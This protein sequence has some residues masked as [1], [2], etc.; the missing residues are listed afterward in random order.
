MVTVN[1]EKNFISAVIYIRNN[2]EN[3]GEFL[4]FINTTLELNFEQYEI[5]CVND[6][7]N[8]HSI[9]KIRDFAKKVKNAEISIL[10]MSFYHGKEISM[11]AGVD[12]SIGDFVY[13]FDTID[14]DY[15]QDLIMEIYYKSL[16]GYDLVK[17][18]PDIKSRLSSKIFYKVFNSYASLPKE[19]KTEMFSILSR[20]AINRIKNVNNEILYRKV[21][22]AS[23]GLPVAE[24]TYLPTTNREKSKDVSRE[25]YRRKL[26]VDS[27]I[28][29]TDVAYVFATRLTFL[30]MAIT[31]LV[32]MY[33]VFTFCGNN[34]VP[35]WTT[36]ILFLSFGFFSM[37]AIMTIL[38]KYLSLIVE[39]NFKKEK[40][41]IE[42]IE[43]V[44]K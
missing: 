28:L 42:S 31:V 24:V 27:L 19:L 38:I 7:S 43:K 16:Q 21:A 9:Q 41:V 39:L 35:G 12:L 32:A 11:N 23:S 40:Y 29:F 13:E 14:I 20:R 5:I 34:P 10:N 37:F 8:D 4:D 44:K 25:K 15:T 17:A 26:A 1:K 18:I 3:V 2:Q 6:A 30:M 33:A 36:N 22:Y